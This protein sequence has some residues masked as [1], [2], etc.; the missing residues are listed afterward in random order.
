MGGESSAPMSVCQKLSGE[1]NCKQ[2]FL[3]TISSVDVLEVPKLEI[4]ALATLPAVFFWEDAKQLWIRKSL[5]AYS[6]RIF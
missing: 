4:A 2:K 3:E 5:L 1:S 6:S